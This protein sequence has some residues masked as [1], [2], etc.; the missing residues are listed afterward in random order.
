MKRPL[1][2]WLASGLIISL[3]QLPAVSWANEANSQPSPST[4]P[5]A[6]AM[7]AVELDEVDEEIPIKGLQIQHQI[8]TNQLPPK[9]IDADPLA[10]LK[11]LK[12]DLNQQIQMQQS[13]TLTTEVTAI[14]T[15]SMRSVFKNLPALKITT[16][17]DKDGKGTSDFVLPEYK[18][19]FV[20]GSDSFL[21]D[22]KG[23]T[24]QL[25]FDKQFKQLSVKTDFSGLVMEEDGE[26]FTLA[27]KTHIGGTFDEL[28]IPQ[29]LKIVLPQ[30]QMTG[31]EEQI[32]IANFMLDTTINRT[33][34]GV[35]LYNLDFSLAEM[36][37]KTEDEED[38][39]E[40]HDLQLKLSNTL[41]KD[42][43]D[44]GLLIKAGELLLPEVMANTEKPMSYTTELK[45]LNIDSSAIAGI[46][47]TVRE[48]QKQQMAGNDMGAMGGFMLLGKLMEVAPQLIAKSPAINLKDIQLVTPEGILNGELTLNLQG[49]KVANW[50]DVP[51]LIAALQ[52]QAEFDMGK[53]LLASLLAT[54][55][56]EE[57]GQDEKASQ[58]A[59][60][61]TIDM[62]LAQKFIVEQEDKYVL[63]ANMSK[64]KLT[65]NERLIPLPF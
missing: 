29:A 48:I 24:G 26:T 6:K 15:D 19:Q 23:V 49:D 62:Y 20:E 57:T 65:V 45:I 30:L 53:T 4:A 35:E 60:Q 3:L 27:D 36:A 55:I 5:N 21:L 40:F 43:V 25:N 39:G 16:T 50:Q 64:G 1:V 38:G 28:M 58:A 54:S 8:G 9:T 41:A 44:Y 13:F 32:N 52:G 14:L 51:A 18:T 12:S 17:V 11:Q 42:K 47:G 10:L 7:L 34:N 37:V 61:Q 31:K 22:W 33:E 63:Q 2:N 56:Q 59:A 46:Q